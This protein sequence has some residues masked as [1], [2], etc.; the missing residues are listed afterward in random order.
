MRTPCCTTWARGS[1]SHCR[2]RSPWRGSAATS[3][4]RSWSPTTLPAT[5]GR[6]RG[7]AARRSARRRSWAGG[8]ASRRPRARPQRAGV[9]IFVTAS[10]GVAT[11]DD[12][13][14][15]LR[16]ADL[17]MYRA[18][19]NGK[20]QSV[21]YDRSLDEAVGE[22]LSLLGELRRARVEEEFVLHYQ[23][24]VDLQTG[25]VVGAEALLRWAHPTRGIVAPNDFVPIAEESGLIVPLGCWVLQEACN[26]LAAWRAS[27]P[28][29]RALHMSVN[30]SA[31]QLPDTA[32]VAQGR[33]APATAGLEA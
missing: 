25:A 33:A 4:P 3:S 17:A 15:V 23:P 21:V 1:A 14:G 19:A 11:G 22:R 6:P 28:A 2:P 12:V 7:A 31:R 10:I 24:V 32:F 13:D 29:A 9:E 5:R 16:R 20:A 26:Q 8:R 27:E 30:V 18:K